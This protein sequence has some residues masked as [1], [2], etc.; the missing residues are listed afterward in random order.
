MLQESITQGGEY[1]LLFPLLTFI[2]IIWIFYIL[3]NNPHHHSENPYN[4]NNNN[5]GYSL[6]RSLEILRERY[7]RGD[8]S[9]E[10]YNK[11][12]KNLES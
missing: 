2:L 7:A 12:K 5:N 6:D 10:E 1:M 8:I 11:I 3:I 9:T 4:R